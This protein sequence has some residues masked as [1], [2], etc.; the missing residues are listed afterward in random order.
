MKHALATMGFSAIVLSL[1]SAQEETDAEKAAAILEK[2][3]ASVDSGHYAS[4]VGRYRN[5]VKDYLNTPAGAIA[6]RRL[7]KN[8]YLGA[9]DLI[10][11]GPSNN[12]VD[13]VSMGDGFELDQQGDFDTLAKVTARNFE[14]YDVFEEYLPYFNFLRV[15]LASQESGVSGYNREY[16]TTLLARRSGAIQGQVA[17]DRSR[18]FA[19]LD[20][21]PDH[22]RLAIVYVKNGDLGT[23]GGGVASVGGRS[24]KTMVH[25]FGHAFASLMDE[26]SSNT[27][28]RGQVSSGPNVSATADRQQVP[29]KH[30]LDAR[31]PGVG[32]YQGADG[33]PKGAWKPTHNCIMDTGVDFCAICREAIVLRIYSLVDP[34]DSCEPDAQ[35][36]QEQ[37]IRI[38]GRST[39]SGDIPTFTVQTIRPKHSLVGRFWILSGQEMIAPTNPDLNRAMRDRGHRGPL[40]KISKEPH[41]TDSVNGSGRFRLTIDPRDLEPG[42]HQ[43]VFR[44]E[45]PTEVRGDRHPWVLKDDRELLWSERMWWVVVVR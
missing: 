21:L 32:V 1:T 28:H 30:W 13:V 34:I 20:E 11:T 23:G 17:V 14:R 22:D 10:R 35:T 18:V 16:D 27:G 26:Y 15:N 38:D 6:K 33:R 24:P 44:V 41:L 3:A 4:V 12:R 8:T 39:T 31:V 9:T 45:D 2:T 37:M 29:W 19:M 5:L 43:V 25:E 42:P 7:D 36:T 40:A